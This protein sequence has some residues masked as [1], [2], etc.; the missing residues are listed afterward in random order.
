MWKPCLMY[1]FGDKRFSKQQ[2]KFAQIAHG[3]VRWVGH[4]FLWWPWTTFTF[5]F[6]NYEFCII[7]I[8]FDGP[9][10]HFELN[11]SHLTSKFPNF[12][13]LPQNYVSSPL[14]PL[15]STWTK[16]QSTCLFKKVKRAINSFDETIPRA[17][18]HQKLF[19]LIFWWWIHK[20]K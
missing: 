3:W 16:I 18:K 20:W 10:L 4:Y 19:N 2:L 12:Q 7:M 9:G 13:T 5:E 1:F 11:S 8:H 6:H 14:Q 15:E 17:F